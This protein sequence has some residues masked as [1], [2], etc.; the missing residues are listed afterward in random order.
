MYI[1]AEHDND[2]GRGASSFS[3]YIIHIYSR[4]RENLSRVYTETFSGD[5]EYVT[6]D[7][8]AF[9]IIIIMVYV[10]VCGGE[11]FFEISD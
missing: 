7:V 8:S 9:K 10:C 1:H 5:D 6:R 4:P 3:H 2:E 11:I